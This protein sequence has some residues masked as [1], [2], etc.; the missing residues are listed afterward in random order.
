ML[1]G[2]LFCLAAA[3]AQPVS[4]SLLARY[5]QMALAYN[6]DLKAAQKNIEAGIELERAARAD[7]MPSLGAGANFRYTGN[8]YEYR[9]TLH[10]T[11]FTW[12]GALPSRR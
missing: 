5:R 1:L 2:G 12:H 10:R 4:D 8:P 11:G 6:D 9:P 7:R 3:V